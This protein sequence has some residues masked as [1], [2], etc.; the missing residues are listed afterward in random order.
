MRFTTARVASAIAFGAVLGGL[1]SAG[2][3][4]APQAVQHS[5]VASDLATGEVQVQ[6]QLMD[7]HGNG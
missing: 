1:A 5:A 6:V 4:D 7:D 3:T 2:D